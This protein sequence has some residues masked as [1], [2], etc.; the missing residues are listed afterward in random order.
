VPAEILMPKNT[1]KDKAAF[2]KTLEKL[3]GLF[4]DN[5]KQFEAMT[6]DKIVAA[7]PDLPTTA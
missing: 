7:G 1:W 6:N 4:Q 3:V 5:F 2:D